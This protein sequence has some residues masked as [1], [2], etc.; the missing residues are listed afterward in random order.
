MTAPLSR[1]EAKPEAALAGKLATA[2]ELPRSDQGARPPTADAPRS[3]FPPDRAALVLLG[4]GRLGIASR[5]PGAADEA[6]GG[7]DLAALKCRLRFWLAVVG[8]L[9]LGCVVGLVLIIL[10]A[11]QV[12]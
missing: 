10:G 12:M 4:D 11:A 2:V 8:A 3:P 7:P 9:V 1:A 6:P 5:G